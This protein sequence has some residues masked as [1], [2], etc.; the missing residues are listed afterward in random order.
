M[1]LRKCPSCKDTVGAESP[2]CPRCGVNFR[3][4]LVRR[5]LKWTTAAVVLGW[6]VSHYTLKL[7]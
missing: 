2:Q 1:V 7:I 6:A 3:A 5:I 4:C